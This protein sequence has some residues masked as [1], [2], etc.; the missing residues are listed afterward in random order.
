MCLIQKKVCFE[1]H[2]CF[3]LIKKSN[4]EKLKSQQPKANKATWHLFPPYIPP[5]ILKKNI[6]RVIIALTKS[7]NVTGNFGCT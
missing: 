4:V 3:L 2:S 7:Y 1:Q 5:S 6:E